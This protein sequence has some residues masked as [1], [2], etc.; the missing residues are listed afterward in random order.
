MRHYWC[1]HTKQTDGWCYRETT[2]AHCDGCGSHLRSPSAGACNV[3]SASYWPPSESVGNN[4]TDIKEDVGR[5][6]CFT[7]RIQSWHTSKSD[8]CNNFSLTPST[9]EIVP[10]KAVQCSVDHQTEHVQRDSWFRPWWCCI[11]WTHRQ[12]CL[13]LCALW[14]CSASEGHTTKTPWFYNQADYN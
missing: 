5:C 11:C 7:P 2:S 9:K 3:P 6:V 4:R 1:W 10:I 12:R 8:C 14:L 13:R